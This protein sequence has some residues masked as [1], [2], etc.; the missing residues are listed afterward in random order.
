MATVGEFIEMAGQILSD[1]GFEHVDAS[2]T[3][4]LQ[5]V[6]D[7]ET[8]VLMQVEARTMENDEP[9]VLIRVVAVTNFERPDAENTMRLLGTLSDLNSRQY[10]GTWF[11]VPEQRAVVLEHS[12]LVNHMSAEEFATIVTMLERTA[13]EVD[14]QLSEYLSGET[15]KETLLKAAERSGMI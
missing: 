13:D 12:L 7:R 11:Y 14:D 2:Q 4:S 15:A 8:S 9:V 5:A 10:F 1:S 6:R 3:E